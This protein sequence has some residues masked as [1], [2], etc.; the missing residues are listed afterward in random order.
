MLPLK[1]NRL[2]VLAAGEGV[3]WGWLAE[4]DWRW[5]ALRIQI[6]VLL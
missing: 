6:R 4:K 2:L 5:L 1:I 3:V